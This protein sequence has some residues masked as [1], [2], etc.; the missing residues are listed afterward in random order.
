M[1]NSRPWLITGGAGY[2]GSHVADKFL[3]AGREIVLFDSLVNGRA[4]RLTYLENKHSRKI[5]TIVGDLRDLSLTEKIFAE[6]RFEGV[7]HAAALKSIQQSIDFPTE[8]MTVNY[9]ATLNLLEFSAKYDVERFIF[10]STAAVYGDPET[11]YS[12][13]EAVEANPKSPYGRS[14]LLSES[15][16]SDFIS[17]EG[18]SGTSLR[19]FNLVGTDHQELADLGSGNL[20][21]KLL[22]NIEA[23]ES[24]KL[25]GY[26]YPTP[27][28]TCI[29][30]YIDVRDVTS[31]IFELANHQGNLPEIMNVGSG[32]GL[33]VLEVI[34][35]IKQLMENTT[36]EVEA[37]ERRQ[38]DAG[39]IYSNIQLLEE[40]IDFKQ[41]YS[42]RESIQS[43]LT[44]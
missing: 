23:G 5:Q 38:G 37:C 24:I 3:E 9:S 2:L 14:K 10:I 44:R 31:V 41:R 12:I 33:S 6:N 19:L 17:Q 34:E 42:I 32:S 15:A 22:S 30:D 40:T 7:I 28:K 35:I 11:N 21:P 39:T 36:I 8:Y 25:F 20:I 18:K 27:D 43:V 4:A 29:R 26:D 16:V 1:R 13:S